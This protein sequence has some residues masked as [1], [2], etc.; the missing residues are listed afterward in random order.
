MS[1]ASWFISFSWIQS[2][3]KLGQWLMT[4]EAFIKDTNAYGRLCNY[5][6]KVLGVNYVVRKIKR[7]SFISQDVWFRGGWGVSYE[8]LSTD[9]R[10]GRQ[11][12]PQVQHTGGYSLITSEGH[13]HLPM[14]AP[15]GGHQS[16]RSTWRRS[17]EAGDCEAA[18]GPGN[19]N[20]RP[21]GS[22]QGAQ[23]SSDRHPIL[24]TPASIFK[25]KTDCERKKVSFM[26]RNGLNHEH[27]LL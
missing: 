3:C 9:Y 11:W 14:W 21:L 15:G 1:I 12:V 13:N 10:G 5:T 7:L 19:W 16:G 2:Q 20:W 8:S 17:T 24:Q 6:F 23:L 4:E 22:W 25:L 18:P 26:D 27:F